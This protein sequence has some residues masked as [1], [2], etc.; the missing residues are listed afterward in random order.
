MSE[1]V[2]CR[3]AVAGSGAV[4]SAARTARVRCITNSP[5]PKQT[6]VLLA[7]NVITGMRYEVFSFEPGAVNL[8]RFQNGAPV[9]LDH[10]YSIESQV[11]VIDR[12]WIEPD[13][14]WAT[15][16]F[17][18]Q[19]TNPESDKYFEMMAQGVISNVS[20][21]AVVTAYEATRDDVPIYTFTQ[22]QPIEL[23][24]VAI[25]A[26]SNA[27]VMSA[28]APVTRN[29]EAAAARMRMALAGAL[30]GIR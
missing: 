25:P 22:W 7:G 27:R 4:D 15:I 21:G 30:A 12:A 2:T 8:E 19:G 11:A 20:I 14:L 13:A 29:H 23:S 3:M 17:P 28:D 6:P 26:D 5:I 16:R 10:D 1:I 9:L 24:I 18:E